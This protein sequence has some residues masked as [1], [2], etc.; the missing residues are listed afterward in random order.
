[1]MPRSRRKLEQH[2][3]WAL[4]RALALLANEPRR[5]VVDERCRDMGQGGENQ[6]APAQS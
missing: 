3:G 1:M 2:R 6:R 5:E 4:A